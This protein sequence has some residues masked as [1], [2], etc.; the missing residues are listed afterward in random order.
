MRKEVKIDWG[1]AILCLLLWFPLLVKTPFYIEE[2]DNEQHSNR[3]EGDPDDS[4]F[5]ED[6]L[7]LSW[8]WLAMLIGGAVFAAYYFF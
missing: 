5:E 3:I 1:W 2:E 4:P 7:D 8:L 6:A